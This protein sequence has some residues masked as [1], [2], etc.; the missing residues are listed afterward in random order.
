M[1][2]AVCGPPIPSSLRC[3]MASARRSTRSVYV[4]RCEHA[5]PS[6]LRGQA[7]RY[8]M[9]GHG[10]VR[11]LRW[12]AMLA[13]LAGGIGAEDPH[14][15]AHVSSCVGFDTSYVLP[16]TL[17]TT[18]RVWRTLEHD[19]PGNGHVGRWAIDFEMP[20]GTPVVAARAGIV[21]AA[22]DS[23]ADDNGLD[24]HENFVFVQHTDGTVARYLHLTR[25]G[26]LARVGDRV[27]QGQVIARSGNSGQSAGP[28]LHF[29][30]QLCGPNLP[31]GYNTLPCGRTVPV[32]F[33]NASPAD[34]ALHPGSW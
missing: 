30:V 34:C 7:M 23:F 13:V 26:A 32:A 18:H 27:R 33:R 5:S 15:R 21:V 11:Q 8:R 31:P 29:D 25:G 14:A 16:Y 3:S 12:G 1:E 4:P 22:R 10:W 6:D 2:H 20:I 19:V 24:L 28:H 17:G 9:G